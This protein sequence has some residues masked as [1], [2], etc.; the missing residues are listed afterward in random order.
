MFVDLDTKKKLCSNEMRKSIIIE[1]FFDYFRIRNKG[2]VK[3][4]INCKFGSFQHQIKKVYNFDKTREKFDETFS[5]SFLS[6]QRV[7]FSLN[8][9]LAINLFLRI[10]IN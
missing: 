6:I 8:P 4:I 2:N 1:N 9:L 7:P 3:L 10:I 5:T